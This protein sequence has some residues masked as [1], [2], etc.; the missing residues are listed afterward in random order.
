MQASFLA[1]TGWECTTL[2]ADGA[3]VQRLSGMPP[4]G[5]FLLTRAAESLD[6]VFCHRGGFL[7]E[8][9]GGRRLEVCAGQVLFLPGRAGDCRCRFA[10]ELFHGVLVREKESA[11]WASL[12][13]LWPGLDCQPPEREHG[14]GVVQAALWCETLFAALEGLPRERQGNYCTVKVLELLYLFHG[15]GGDAAQTGPVSY[16]DR[17]QLQTVRKVHDYL[18]EHLDQR[19]TIRQLCQRFPISGTL[20]KACFRQLYGAPIHQYILERRMARAAQLLCSTDQTV[21]QIALAVGYSS[22]SQF[23]VAFRSRYHMPPAQFR[24]NAKK[25]SVTV[26]SG[27]NQREISS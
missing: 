19:L 18:L 13:A 1:W 27:P 7:L 10:Q 23:G 12:S 3:E 8:F 11:L 5:T 25:M 22:V 16:H 21:L 4:A 24:R 9:P 17:H 6:V 14:C 26:C 20:L 2:P 15:G